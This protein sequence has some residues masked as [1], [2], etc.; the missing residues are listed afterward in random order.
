M[1]REVKKINSKKRVELIVLVCILIWGVFVLVDYL[2]Y[3][4]G[5]PPIFALHT[6]REYTDGEVRE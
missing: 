1:Y 5:K 3:D 6:T 4:S 2:R